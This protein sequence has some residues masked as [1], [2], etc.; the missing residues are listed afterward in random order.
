MKMLNQKIVM[1]FALVMLTLA[2]T[3]GRAQ[4]AGAQEKPATVTAEQVLDGH[5]KAIGGVEKLNNFKNRR[6]SATL[7][8]PAVG[9]KGPMKITQ[10]AP[11]HFRMEMELPGIG[12]MLQV[13]DG[14]NVFDKNP[15]TGQRT[16]SGAE[17]EAMMLES[18]FNSETQWKELYKS[19]SYEGREDVDG[20]PCHKILLETPSG[21][22]RTHYYDAST[23][24]LKKI[25]AVVKSPQGELETESTLSDYKEVDGVKFAHKTIVSVLGQQ[26]VV[27]IE[28]I[29]HDVELA[30]DAFSIPGK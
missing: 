5:V 7:S 22:K 23:G 25:K 4:I 12:K 15:L 20:K 29:E 10:E 2:S 24:L 17:K 13:C 26:Q 19:V 27:E 3:S 1:R 9:L 8:M 30:D 28:K 16:L 14:E 6:T 11:N 21:S 18:T